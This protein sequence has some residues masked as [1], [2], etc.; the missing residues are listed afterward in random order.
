MLVSTDQGPARMQ[1]SADHELSHLSLRDGNATVQAQV[2]AVDF[3]SKT[4]SGFIG[5]YRTHAPDV[6]VKIYKEARATAERNG[7]DAEAEFNKIMADELVA[8]WNSGRD[9]YAG[10]FRDAGEARRLRDEWKQQSGKDR[11]GR[12]D[13]NLSRRKGTA[14]RVGQNEGMDANGR[15]EAKS[16][17]GASVRYEISM[18]QF[19]EVGE[20]ERSYLSERPNDRVVKPKENTIARSIASAIKS[21]FGVKMYYVV[22]EKGSNYA[23]YNYSNVN[24]VRY[25]SVNVPAVIEAQDLMMGIVGHEAGHSAETDMDFL[26]LVDSSMNDRDAHRKFLEEYYEN[27][28]DK[29]ENVDVQ[30]EQASDIVAALFN[31]ERFWSFVAANTNKRNPALASLAEA[32]IKQIRAPASLT[33]PAMRKR[34]ELA[35]QPVDVEEK[36]F[37]SFMRFLKRRETQNANMQKKYGDK[38]SS[39]RYEA[40]PPTPT[41]ADQAKALADANRKTAAAER[42]TAVVKAALAKF[43]K[44]SAEKL[45]KM[46]EQERL[47]FSTQAKQRFA[48]FMK[49]QA[50]GKTPK[51]VVS[52]AFD[53]GIDEESG[54]AK[55]VDKVAM[56][57]SPN[58]KGG[59]LG[60]L[61]DMLDALRGIQRDFDAQGQDQSPEE[62]RRLIRER[63]FSDSV[64]AASIIDKTYDPKDLLDRMTKQVE[65]RIRATMIPDLKAARQKYG[66]EGEAYKDLTTDSKELM[67]RFLDMMDIA[68][69]LENV[70]TSSETTW[71]YAPDGSNNLVVDST[72]QDSKVIGTF[73]AP[74]NTQFFTDKSFIDIERLHA[75]LKGVLS[76]NKEEEEANAAARQKQTEETGDAARAEINKKAKL[77]DPDETKGARLETQTP[78]EGQ[79]AWFKGNGKKWRS[80]FQN[81]LGKDG[82][83]WKMVDALRKGDSLAKGVSADAREKLMEVFKREGLSAEDENKWNTE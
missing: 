78:D 25:I 19:D 26:K 28:K 56:T 49:G 4:F 70:P 68:G 20:G 50:K 21:I 7:T 11:Q 17:V 12:V 27:H 63:L 8:Y 57:R 79:K 42:K 14:D 6:L 24:G 15:S 40:L 45:S 9:E 33:Y 41:P 44:S 35:S 52:E 48:E 5:Q 67:K 75:A 82:I 18:D 1:Q 43:R 72:M 76:G 64:Q 29:I 34:F 36:M 59:A 22:P 66:S 3:E 2:D 74:S 62:L 30:S 53:A 55:I 39:I 23:A 65:K 47:K 69:A 10:A 58:I 16:D 54:I 32:A 31:N 77:R 71:D 46:S 37:D 61:H 81:K 83:V 51:A 73:D 38:S 60:K 13:T 80:Y